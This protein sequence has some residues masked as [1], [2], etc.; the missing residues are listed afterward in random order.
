MYNILA[1]SH[2]GDR[3]GIPDLRSANARRRR[4]HLV[5]VQSDCW[6]YTQ[7][8]SSMATR[9]RRVVNGEQNEENQSDGNSETGQSLGTPGVSQEQMMDFMRTF[10]TETRELERRERAEIEEE[11]RRERNEF[12]NFIKTM[13]DNSQSSV[14]DVWLTRLEERDD[15]EAYLAAFERKMNAH[16]INRGSWAYRLAPY[17]TGRAQQAFAAMDKDDSNNYNLVKESIFKTLRYHNNNLP[18]TFPGN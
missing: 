2:F 13:Q 18:A 12:M 15:M 9:S 8:K 6:T 5:P 16:S 11:R 1:L 4:P 14:A 10:L 7:Q 17:L 3:S